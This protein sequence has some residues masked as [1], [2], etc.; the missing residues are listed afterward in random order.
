MK[1]DNIFLL[2]LQKSANQLYN[3]AKNSEKI[4]TKK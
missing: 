3:I 4:G 1:T 2:F